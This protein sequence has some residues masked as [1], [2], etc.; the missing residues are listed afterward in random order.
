M[1]PP[2]IQAGKTPLHVASING[3]RDCAELLLGRKAD[4]NLQDNVTRGEDWEV[5]A[6][7]VGADACIVGVWCYGVLV[8]RCGFS[9]FGELCVRVCA[10]SCVCACVCVFRG[11][12]WLGL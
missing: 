10:R 11:G 4:V 3:R 5:A 8:L 7:V 12:V 9:G 2:C 1:Q 6:M